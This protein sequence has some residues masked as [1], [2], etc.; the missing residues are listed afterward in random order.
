MTG[1]TFNGAPM[2]RL[3]RNSERNTFD[4]ASSNPYRSYTPE[5]PVQSLKN[6]QS[7]QP[8]P[9]RVQR[10]ISAPT[11]S[12][13]HSTHTAAELSEGARIEHPTFGL[14]VIAKVDT[15]RP[16]HRIVVDFGRRHAP[17]PSSEIR[18]FQNIVIIHDRKRI[19]HSFLYR[20]RRPSTQ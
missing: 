17:H 1:S 9:N 20:I 4:T 3:S 16:D 12:G 7:T 8:V 5:H 13:G 14:G 2:S 19:T 6:T 10:P 11:T 18:T 15:T